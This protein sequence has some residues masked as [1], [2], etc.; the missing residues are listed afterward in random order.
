M[1]SKSPDTKFEMNSNG[2]GGGA[3]NVKV[4]NKESIR[5]LMMSLSELITLKKIKTTQRNGILKRMLHA[6]S[7]KIYDI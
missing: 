7:F 4:I 6:P 2:N 3:P 1:I 5:N